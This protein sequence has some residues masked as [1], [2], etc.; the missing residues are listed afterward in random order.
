MTV[1][2]TASASKAKTTATPGEQINA[3]L[4][5]NA[6]LV[7]KASTEAARKS[8]DTAVAVTREPAAVALKTGGVAIKDYDDAVAFG[9]DN[10]DVAAEVGT[11][12]VRGLQTLGK[13]WIDQVQ[14][15][16]EELPVAFKAFAAC[17]TVKEAADLQVEY[18][19]TGFEDMVNTAVRFQ[20]LGYQLAT[21]TFEPLNKRVAETV[22]KYGKPFAA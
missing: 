2:S 10:I 1:N 18:V 7:L 13:E 14:K 17:K 6:Q 5:E 12:A 3:V 9:R 21:A 15:S 11:L 19:K 16:A 20:Q 8:Y 4:A 22:T